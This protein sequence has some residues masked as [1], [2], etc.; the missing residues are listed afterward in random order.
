M[1][2][3]MPALHAAVVSGNLLKAKSFLAE[4]A[5]LEARDQAGWTALLRAIEKGHRRLVE[6][7]LKAGADP[8]N[9][10]RLTPVERWTRSKKDKIET[11]LSFAAL[12]GDLRTW[13]F[14]ARLVL[15]W[16]VAAVSLWPA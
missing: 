7:L 1:K 12:L 14:C 16:T 13:S 8:N 11:P 2:D 15:V 4:G 3:Q 9:G 5:D 6:L 10:R